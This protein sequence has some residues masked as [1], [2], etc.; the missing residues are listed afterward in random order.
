[1]SSGREALQGM[2]EDVSVLDPSL[3]P[4]LLSRL[5]QEKPL[6]RSPTETTVSDQA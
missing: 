3:K 1:M 2:E 4:A 5:G 6:L